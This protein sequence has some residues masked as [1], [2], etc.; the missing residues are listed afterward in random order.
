M[1]RWLGLSAFTARGPGSTPDQGPKILQAVQ[2]DQKKEALA[3]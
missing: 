2:L 3:A 1:V